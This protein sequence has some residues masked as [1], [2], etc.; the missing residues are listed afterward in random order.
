MLNVIYF[1]YYF[2]WAKTFARAL[3]NNV[4]FGIPVFCIVTVLGGCP[5]AVDDTLTNAGFVT[6]FLTALLLISAGFDDT[7]TGFDAAFA[8]AEALAAFANAA[9]FANSAAFCLAAAAFLACNCFNN[10]I[11]FNFLRSAELSFLAGTI[12]D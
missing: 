11:N 12:G 8:A 6:T 1:L 10:N 3:A 7:I 4:L 2:F 9:A 5:A